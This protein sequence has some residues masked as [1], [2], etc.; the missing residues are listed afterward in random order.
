MCGRGWEGRGG[1]ADSC[2]KH[3]SNYPL[4]SGFF[5]PGRP[6]TFIL[7]ISQGSGAVIPVFQVGKLRSGSPRSPSLSR[8][9]PRFE[10]RS[11]RFQTRSPGCLR[12]GLSAGAVAPSL[13]QA[14]SP[15]SDL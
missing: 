6:P 11:S 2:H 4:L 15:L 7:W 14:P 3:S 12:V 1:R 13:S 10:L 9:R 8:R 5:A